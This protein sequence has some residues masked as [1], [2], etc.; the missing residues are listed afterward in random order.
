MSY[1]KKVSKKAVESFLG[2]RIIPNIVCIGAD[3]AMYHTA[4]A[5][6]RT[7]DS[8]VILES[9]DKI[10]VPKLGRKMTTEMVLDNID[11]YTEQ[12]D[13]LKSDWSKK[14]KFDYAKIEDAFYQFS[15]KT[16]KVLAYNGII[17]YDRLKRICK[18]A[19]FMM[20]NSARA[21]INY[22]K[23]KKKMTRTELKNSI[24]EYI[25]LTLDYKVE[26]ED[27]A[28][29]IVLALAGCVMET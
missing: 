26:T 6:I 17:T 9:L 7:T 3:T 19:T 16:T 23:P 15:V 27:E 21:K 12:L 20:P 28:D 2:V 1:I 29:S 24:M 4:F 13:Q 18:H 11:L 10:E 22:K 25:N 5:V 8:Y 14:H